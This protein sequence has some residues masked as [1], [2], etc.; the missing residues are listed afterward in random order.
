MKL[1]Y[2]IPIFLILLIT[3]GS[4]WWFDH[5]NSDT[6]THY[7]GTAPLLTYF[8]WRASMLVTPTTTGAD[9]ARL[10]YTDEKLTGGNYTW[11][12]S[13]TEEDH[14]YI[15]FYFGS[16]NAETN[17]Y[18]VW[19]N[20]DPDGTKYFGYINTGGGTFKLYKTIAGAVTQLDSEVPGRP[21]YNNRKICVIVF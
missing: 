2:L 18:T 20:P 16:A 19:G 7:T 6:S 8:N 1:W 15:H 17:L 4:A 11:N 3:P 21:I 13:A 9:R 5:F 12:F 10:F 14:M